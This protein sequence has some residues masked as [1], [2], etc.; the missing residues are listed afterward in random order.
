MD[1][2]PSY[3]VA[4]EQDN[5]VIRFK[6]DVIDQATLAQF[7]DYLELQSIRKRSQLS[8]DQATALADEID[9]SVWD[10]LKDT[11]GK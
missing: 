10:T 2:N 9:R 3:S 6:R 7:L 8:E 11:F 4:V 1:Y 5:V